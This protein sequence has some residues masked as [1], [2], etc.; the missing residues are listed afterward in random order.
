MFIALLALLRSSVVCSLQIAAPLAPYVGTPDEAA[1][2][3]REETTRRSR[4]CC[5]VEQLQRSV[6]LLWLVE[7][8]SAL[9]VDYLD[10]VAAVEFA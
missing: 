1:F 7:N 10:E 6:R 2:G 9:T 4:I 8:Y 5:S 3:S